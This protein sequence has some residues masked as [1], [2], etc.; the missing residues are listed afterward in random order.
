M[1]ICLADPRMNIIASIPSSFALQAK[2][3]NSRENS[4]Q[5]IVFL[6]SNKYMHAFQ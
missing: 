1:S 5:K 4:S 3:V 2:Y 6:F